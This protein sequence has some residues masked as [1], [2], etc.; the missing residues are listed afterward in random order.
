V[1]RGPKYMSQ[2]FE[3]WPRLS[4]ILP[5]PADADSSLFDVAVGWG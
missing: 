2:A 1:I 5:L 3:T 4:L